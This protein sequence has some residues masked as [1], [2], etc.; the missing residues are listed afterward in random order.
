[1]IL[2]ERQTR[3]NHVI[4]IAK[5]MMNAARTAPKGKGVDII[6]IKTV[7]GDDIEKLAQLTE[8]QSEKTG[9]KFFLRDAGNIRNAQAV[10]LIGTRQLTHGLN[11][12]HCGFDTCASKPEAVPCAINSIDVGIA[13][14]SACATASDLRADTRVM[15]SVGYSAQKAG[16]M[17]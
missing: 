10:L 2:D 4:E 7:C 13:V 9:M 1:M 17:E 11:C 14:G 15:F 5:Q 3:E 12:G 6:E 8:E 16:W